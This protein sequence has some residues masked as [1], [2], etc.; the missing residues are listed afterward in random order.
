MQYNASTMALNG[1]ITP[2]VSALY[3]IIAFTEL[4]FSFLYISLRHYNPSSLSIWFRQ[5]LSVSLYFPLYL[6][7]SL[8]LSLSIFFRQHL[9]FSFTLSLSLF[10][11][12]SLPLSQ[13]LFANISFSLSLSL[14]SSLYIFL[15]TVAKRFLIVWT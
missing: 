3:Y 5:N 13:S 11:T 6:F 4:T 8:S 15:T 7:I 10:S 2:R 12:I 9:S 14:F 1:D